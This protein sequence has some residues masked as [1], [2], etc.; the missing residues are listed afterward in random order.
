MSIKNQITYK[1]KK[2]KTMVPIEDVEPLDSGRRVIPV[3]I[4]EYEVDGTKEYFVEDFFDDI[5]TE[6]ILSS[7][8][9]KILC[10]V[11]YEPHTVILY[12]GS[13]VPHNM[14]ITSML[15][16]IK[17]T[18]SRIDKDQIMD[19]FKEMRFN[20]E[21]K[22][23]L[24]SASKLLCARINHDTDMNYS[25]MFIRAALMEYINDCLFVTDD[26]VREAICDLSYNELL[27]VSCGLLEIKMVGFTKKT[28]VSAFLKN[29][30]STEEFEKYV[31]AEIMKRLLNGAIREYE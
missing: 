21:H 9:F 1:V 2:W 22:G 28:L 26:G 15:N 24:G 29:G 16:D 17:S 23:K 6:L 19:A 4:G 3:A 8:E 13:I 20:L 18:L 30:L 11:N 14:A 10:D 31:T 12:N 25:V 7:P 5:L 27:D